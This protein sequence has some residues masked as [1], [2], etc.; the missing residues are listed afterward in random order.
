MI[1]VLLCLKKPHKEKIMEEEKFSIPEEDQESRDWIILVENHMRIVE[2]SGKQAEQ[3]QQRLW[4]SQM[5]SYQTLERT[6]FKGKTKFSHGASLT[7]GYVEKFQHVVRNF[8]ASNQPPEHLVR[9]QTLE[10]KIKQHQKERGELKEKQQ[11]LIKDSLVLFHRH[12]AQS[13]ALLQQLEKEKAVNA[14]HL[15]QCRILFEHAN[16]KVEEL[17]KES[18]KTASNFE[19]CNNCIIDAGKF[20]QA[21]YG[22][23]IALIDQQPALKGMQVNGNINVDRANIVAGG[24]IHIGPDVTINMSCETAKKELEDMLIGK[25]KAFDDIKTKHDALQQDYQKKVKELASSQEK[26]KQQQEDLPR[27]EQVLSDQLAKVQQE[28]ESAKIEAEQAKEQMEV[29]RKRIAQLEA[30]SA[31]QTGNPKQQASQSTPAKAI[32]ARGLMPKPQPRQ[33]IGNNPAPPAAASSS[34]RQRI[35]QWEAN[36]AGKEAKPK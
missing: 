22:S 35:A 7:K 34:M 30:D 23:I 14:I 8:F 3:E 19:L 15:Q 28:A 21:G 24:N 29:M 10:G 4:K 25:Q 20:Y 9:M 17:K 13:D 11:N 12:K 33:V 32:A 1:H 2:A 27:R 26:L 18:I 36:S 5:E 6:F 31:T 16:E